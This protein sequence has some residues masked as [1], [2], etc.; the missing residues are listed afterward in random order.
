MSFRDLAEV[1]VIITLITLGCYG[2]YYIIT[3]GVTH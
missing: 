3:F 1:V 2:M